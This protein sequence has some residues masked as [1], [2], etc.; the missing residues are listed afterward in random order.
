[1]SADISSTAEKV[2][3]QKS[4]SLSHDAP[5]MNARKND[6]SVLN[7]NNVDLPPCKE[8][9]RMALSAVSVLSRL[10][11]KFEKPRQPTSLLLSSVA[12]Y[13]EKPQSQMGADDSDDKNSKK[14]AHKVSFHVSK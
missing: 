2:P 14:K 8:K 7:R 11:K 5:A 9:Q 12:Q 4:K 1:M 13:G 10:Q 6:E 3:R